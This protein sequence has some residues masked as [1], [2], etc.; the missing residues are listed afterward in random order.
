MPDSKI[1][2]SK[3][4]IQFLVL[5][6][7]I[8]LMLGKFIAYLITHSNAI[9]TDALESIINVVAGCFGLYSLLLASKPKDMEK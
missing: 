7:G 6:I 9:L 2:N 8:L 4:R 3:I 1:I 5:S